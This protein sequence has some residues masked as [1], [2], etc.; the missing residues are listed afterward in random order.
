MTSIKHA[1][2][3]HLIPL[4][5]IHENLIEQLLQSSIE[6]SYK[7]K[8]TV[9]KATAIDDSFCHY[10]LDGDYELRRTF[11]DRTVYSANEAKAQH[12]LE[13]A[14]SKGGAI[15]AVTACRVLAVE[16]ATLDR[17]L[18]WSQQY[19]YEILDSHDAAPTLDNIAIDDD[20]EADWSHA[21]I[22]KPLASNLS[23]SSLHELFSRIQP[24]DVK[25]DEVII[26]S[27]TPPDYFYI[28]KSGVAQIE[29]DSNG[30]FAGR[31]FELEAGDYFGDEAIVAE[32]LRNARVKML[33]DGVLLRL[34]IDD[35]NR[36]ISNEIVKRRT[37]DD[38]ASVPE[39]ARYFIDVRLPFELQ[40]EPESINKENI[41]ISNLRKQLHSFDPDK[42]YYIDSNGG[43]RSELATYLMRQAGFEAYCYT[44]ELCEDVPKAG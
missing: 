42:V 19:N 37:P 2:L 25:S 36:L 4:A 40:G 30:P 24:L 18:A 35:F 13:D 12:S 44:K 11:D 38:A 21:F 15:K 10:I 14:L 17:L 20:Y 41:P 1:D 32:T 6:T 34:H 22:S 39:C 16:I 31:T 3:K 33:S 8:S 23:S 9:L 28:I 26:Q 27:A 5:N 43:R 7:P 29:T